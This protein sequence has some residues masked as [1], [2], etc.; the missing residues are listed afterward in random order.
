MSNLKSIIPG[1]HH[2]PRFVRNQSEQFEARSVMVEILESKS[3]F[4]DGMQGSKMPIAVAHGEGRAEMPEV[5]R[6]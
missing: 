3:I 5:F 1:A 4:L 6:G 2:W